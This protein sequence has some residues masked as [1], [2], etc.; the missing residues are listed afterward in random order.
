MI[1]KKGEKNKNEDKTQDKERGNRFSLYLGILSFAL[2][3]FF[4]CQKIHIW[5]NS[6]FINLHFCNHTLCIF[7]SL[8]WLFLSIY[9][10]FKFYKNRNKESKK[11]DNENE[12]NEN[13]KKTIFIGFLILI[14]GIILMNLIICYDSGIINIQ[15]SFESFLNENP[16]IRDKN[17]PCE[18]SSWPECMGYC[19]SGR[20]M[21]LDKDGIGICWCEGTEINGS[22]SGITP[23]TNI[24]NGSRDEPVYG[25]CDDL[26]LDRGFPN[27]QEEVLITNVCD[28]ISEEDCDGKPGDVFYDSE[29]FCCLWNCDE[30]TSPITPT[31]PEPQEFCQDSDEGLDPETPGSCNDGEVYTDYCIDNSNLMEYHCVD[32]VCVEVEYQCD[33]KCTQTDSGGF[34]S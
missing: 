3:L 34:C 26:A 31:P 9:Q 13:H 14:I 8:I 15:G 12:K 10:F 27:W 29:T 1:K 23:T 20:C 21:P 16:T 11:K 4:F 33:L 30:P 22:T 24:S 7:Y 2:F 25:N 18:K 19:S 5:A 17:N 32:N 28:E 6:T